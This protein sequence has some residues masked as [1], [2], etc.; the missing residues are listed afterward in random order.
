MAISGKR[1]ILANNQALR[2]KDQNGDVQELLKLDGAGQIAGKVKEYI[3]AQNGIDQ[4][5][6][7]DLQSRTAALESTM[8]TKADQS[9]LDFETSQRQQIDSILDGRITTQGQE[10][11]ALEISVASKASQADLD[12]LDGYAQD[13]RSDHDALEVR[14][15]TAEGEIDA[16]QLE[17]PNKASVSSVTALEGRMGTAEGEIDTLQSEMDAAEL[18][19]STKLDA[20]LKG[21][22]N[23]VAE[24]DSSGKVPASQLP[25]VQ[26]VV[27]H[28]MAAKTLSASDV[29][30]GYIDL[31]HEAMSGSISVF[32]ERVAI[33]E[34]LDYSVSSSG[35]V[36]RLTWIGPS[37]AGA[38]EEFAEGDVVYVQYLQSL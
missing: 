9:A 25:V 19:I 1:I 31:G 7:T 35:G 5:E 22:P 34:G 17:M 32:C 30:N 36:S 10:I 20:S 13:I 16:L 3:D 38:E 6:I 8:P 4:G 12:D 18:A 14:V 15:G 21:A 23:G 26:S 33:L 2:A 28:K 37:A 11:D 27:A 24:L 29:A